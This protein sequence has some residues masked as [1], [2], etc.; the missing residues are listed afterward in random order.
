MLPPDMRALLAGAANPEPGAGPPGGGPTDA[1]PEQPTPQDNLQ[2]LRDAIDAAQA[3]V[4]GEDDDVHKQTALTCIAK[5]QS[6]LAEEQKG[7]DD[8]LQ[9]KA[10]PRALRRAASGPQV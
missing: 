9:G 1:P 4:D 2:S 5:L 10:N 7:A 6:I 8:L 3:Y